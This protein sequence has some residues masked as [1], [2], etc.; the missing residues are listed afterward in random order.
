MVERRGKRNQDSGDE[1]GDI[2]AQHACEQAAFKDTYGG[3]E[4]M[5]FLECHHLVPTGISSD[6]VLIFSHPIGWSD[7]HE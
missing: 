3:V 1:P 7:D 6:T 4:G 5:V 2:S